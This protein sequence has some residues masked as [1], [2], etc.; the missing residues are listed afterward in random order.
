MEASASE[1]QG[2]SRAPSKQLYVATIK[3]TSTPFRADTVAL[4]YLEVAPKVLD[5]GAQ[6]YSFYRSDDDADKFEH[7]SYWEDKDDFEAYW[8][9]RKMQALRQDVQ[10]MVEMPMLPHWH[11]MLEN[12]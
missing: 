2:Q 11:T 10:G 9:S 3:F 1:T 4:R 5:F 6:S 8:F 7:I 12:G